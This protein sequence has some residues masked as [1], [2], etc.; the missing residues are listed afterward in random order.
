MCADLKINVCL[1]CVGCG[2]DSVANGSSLRCAITHVIRC[3]FHVHFFSAVFC[4][5]ALALEGLV[6]DY[7]IQIHCVSKL[8]MKVARL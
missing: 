7:I 5:F 8:A 1:C 2:G 6:T 3:H 4:V